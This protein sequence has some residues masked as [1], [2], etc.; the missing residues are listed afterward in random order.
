MTSRK[1]CVERKKKSTLV[2]RCTLFFQYIPNGYKVGLPDSLSKQN[3]E[4]VSHY[5]CKNYS[6][7][8]GAQGRIYFI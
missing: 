5:A 6:H 4:L 2:S 8:F 3:H 1:G 7:L